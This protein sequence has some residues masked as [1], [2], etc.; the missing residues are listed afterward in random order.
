MT[1]DR[2]YFLSAFFGLLAG[3]MFNYA[4]VI[5]SHFLSEDKSFAST[6]FFVAYLPFLLFS[7]S[8]GFILDK[9]SRKLI[10]FLS[11][12]V[13]ASCSFIPGLLAYL[14]YLDSSNKEILYIFAF[15]N[16]VALSFIMP[17]R[18]AV[19]GELVP[20]ENISKFTIY[21]NFIILLGFALSPVISGLI[22]E[23]YSYATLL[24]TTGSIYFL[25]AI[26]LSIIPIPHEKIHNHPHR[27]EALKEAF[28]FVKKEKTVNQA[29]IAMFFGMFVVGV[30]QVLLPDFAKEI[31]KLDEKER[32]SLMGM[33]GLGLLLGSLFSI[34]I[35]KLIGRGKCIL[36]SITLSGILMI[37]IAIVTNPFLSMTVLLI[38]GLFLGTVTS[39][40]PSIIQAAT[41]NNLR[42]RVMS[43]FSL[44]FLLTPALSGLGYGF[45]ADKIGLVN[46][47]IVSGIVAI[48]MGIVGWFT[49]SE[50]KIADKKLNLPS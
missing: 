42:G 7:F 10:L 3:N 21:L 11:Q 6:V 22:R 50:L 18:F 30:I 29:L 13:T 9:H 4:I 17:G 48:L 34:S 33:L 46:V 8:A 35:A 41:P 15:I 36:I 44:V 28:N 16:G 5:F 19:L 47:F 31:L 24:M 45:L 12:L 32:G 27:K 37:V 39:F 14:G 23:V 20:H 40:V 49:L 43:Y 2:I 38:A 26:V 25:S 1:K